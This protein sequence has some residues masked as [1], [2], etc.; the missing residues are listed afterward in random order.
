MPELDVRLYST[1][2]GRVPFSEWFDALR[3][4]RTQQRVDARL[5]RIREG[6]L[7]D[8]K[9]LGGGLHEL[10]LDFGPGYRVYF[11]KQGARIVVLL[12][13]GQKRGQERDIRRA[14]VYLQDLRERER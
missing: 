5:G 6:N 7:G 9:D 2:D 4:W 3:N 10:R 8:H 13:G 11:A 1:P 12:A 14:R